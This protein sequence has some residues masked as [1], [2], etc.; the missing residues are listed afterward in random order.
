MIIYIVTDTYFNNRD[1]ERFGIDFFLSKNFEVVVIDAQD[2]TNPELRFIENPTHEEEDNL[3]VAKCSNFDDV[4][5]TIKLH[6]QGIA[7][8]FLSGNIQSTK[9]KKYLKLH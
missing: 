5:K 1:K 8:V 2:Y 9:I 6:G 7:I 3:F 4:K